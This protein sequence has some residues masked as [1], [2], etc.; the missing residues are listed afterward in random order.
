MQ[1]FL[2]LWTQRPAQGHQGY[3]PPLQGLVVY[4]KVTVIPERTAPR[5]C[6]SFPC[7]T[8]IGVKTR[9]S[10]RKVYNAEDTDDGIFFVC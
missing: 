4:E 1:G 3:P 9:Q 7:H 6:N 8:Q 5:L 2:C 10:R